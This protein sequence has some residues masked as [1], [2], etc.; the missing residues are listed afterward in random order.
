METFGSVNNSGQIGEHL[1]DEVSEEQKNEQ[2]Q[3]MKV[4]QGDAGSQE[5]IIENLENLDDSA[6]LIVTRD[7]D[8]FK[9]GIQQDNTASSVTASMA[10]KADTVSQNMSNGNR[11]IA[12]S[13]H[14]SLVSRVIKMSGGM[15]QHQIGIL[16][17]SVSSKYRQ[18][19]QNS[20][21]SKHSG[22]SRITVGHINN[23][24]ES[25]HVYENNQS[26]QQLSVAESREREST[27][28][29]KR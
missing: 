26:L 15:K 2:R 29:F 27:G 8:Q 18:N 3:T 13:Q 22:R 6:A 20:R 12:S 21:S 14:G 28:K 5:L 19:A 11:R 10:E 24:M 16:P 1:D 25:N 7:G 23:A 4:F 9:I 17:P